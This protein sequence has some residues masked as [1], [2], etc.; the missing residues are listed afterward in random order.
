M[1]L[2]YVIIIML[3]IVGA[4][5][6]QTYGRKADATDIAVR[7]GG[8]RADERWP[9]GCQDDGAFPLY[10][11]AEAAAADA[12]NGNSHAYQGYFMPYDQPW[13]S[14]WGVLV[15][16]SGYEGDAPQCDC[17]AADQDPAAEDSPSDSESDGSARRGV[18]VAASFAL[19][20]AAAAL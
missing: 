9:G 6:Q 8:R 1:E 13:A 4:N 11:T 2:L 7:A 3:A 18:L 16:R 10:C 5:G 14:M 20:A 12:P 15:W 17:D 19:F